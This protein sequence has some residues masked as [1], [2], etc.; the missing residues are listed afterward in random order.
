MNV[1]WMWSVMERNL[2]LAWIH[3]FIVIQMFEYILWFEYT[4][5]W[6]CKH[7]YVILDIN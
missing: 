6:I 2:S 4:A 7:M 3:G 5:V 1:A